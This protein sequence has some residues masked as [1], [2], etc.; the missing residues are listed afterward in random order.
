MITARLSF[1]GA[2][3]LHKAVFVGVQVLLYCRKIDETLMGMK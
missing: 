3:C 1:R 2:L